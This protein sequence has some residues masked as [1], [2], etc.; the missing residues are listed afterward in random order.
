MGVISSVVKP[1]L[2]DRTTRRKHDM[3]PDADGIAGELQGFSFRN[4][5]T[6]STGNTFGN[7]RLAVG[8]E[9]AWK[10]EKLSAA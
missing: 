6:E 1:G 4:G 10:I 3:F 5:E 2:S 8:I 7:G 9:R